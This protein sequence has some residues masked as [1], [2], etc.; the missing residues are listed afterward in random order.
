L[1]H[2]SKADLTLIKTNASPDALPLKIAVSYLVLASL[3]SWC[4]CYL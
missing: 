2:N 3:C 4:H 1:Y